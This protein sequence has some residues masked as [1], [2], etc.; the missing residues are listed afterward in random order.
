[1]NVAENLYNYLKH[2][3]KAELIGF[4]TFYVQNTSA[5]I[6][7]LS[8][9]VT[10]PSR[11][12]TF[13]DE[14]KGD[15]NFVAY[16]AEKEFISVKTAYTW[17]QQYSNSLTEK[18]SSGKDVIIP[19]I[20][21]F[22]CGLLNE[23]T[24]V[25]ESDPNLLDNSFGLS[26][27]NNVKTYDQTEQN[28]IGQ[29]LSELNNSLAEQKKKQEEQQRLEEQQAI[30]EQEQ[31]AKNSE[32][33]IA[34]ETRS[35]NTA[36]ISN[37]EPI[38]IQHSQA[39]IESDVQKPI[40]E[41]ASQQGLD[42]DN[43]TKEDKTQQTIDVANQ[44]N[45]NIIVD[46]IKPASETPKSESSLQDNKDDNA[47]MGAWQPQTEKKEKRNWKILC[48]IILII[49]IICILFLGAHYMGWLKNIPALKPLED[50]LSIYIPIKTTT[51]ANKTIVA[52]PTETMTEQTYTGTIDFQES[53]DNLT[54]DTPN[55]KVANNKTTTK[56]KKA[57]EPPAQ[58][59][60]DKPKAVPDNTPVTTQTYS[61]LGFDVIAGTYS[62]KAKA[63]TAARKAKSLGYDGYVLSKIKAGQPIYYVSYG[64]R[65]TLNEANDLMQKMQDRLGGSYTVISR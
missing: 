26:P 10:P 61:K 30:L 49:L 1:M 9:S 34:T 17:I 41:D 38:V 47:L 14:Q 57:P 46:D 23:C 8:G 32:D 48:K 18:L 64:S 65:R 58:P 51:K 19:N 37:Q 44:S 3:T 54:Q 11:V 52:K 43:N 15:N 63:E 55:N 35:N 5:H 6:D 45:N 12:L 40:N 29:E 24:F 16:M 59:S 60:Q 36:E 13:T 33:N 27:I 39:E 42:L 4:G 25:P 50:K 2:H 20:G 28:T 22:K 56:N 53:V 31:K 21:Q 7:E 62:E